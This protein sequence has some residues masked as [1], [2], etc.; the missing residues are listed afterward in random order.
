MW[1]LRKI[2]FPISLVYAF[3]VYL[4]NY[5]YNTKILS[6]NSFKTPTICIG[7]LSV[8][9]TGKTP[10]I[11]FL[12]SQFKDSYALVVLSRGYGRK[13]KGF[14]E[15]TPNSKVE[16]IG[17]E[18]F[19]IYSKFPEIKVV[20]DE[21]RSNAISRIEKEF[22]SDL[23]LLDD[24]YQHRKVTPSVSILLTTCQNL[25]SDDW[26]LPT[27][28]LRDSKREA[29][30]ADIIVVTKCPS[31][32]SVVEQKKIVGKLKSEF[33]QEVLFSYL[34]YGKSIVGEND[35]ISLEDY[36]NQEITLVT[37]IANPRP[38]QD[39]LTS[40]NVKFEHLKYKDHHFFT[41]KEL[42]IF[43]AKKMILTTEKDFVR[44]KNKVDNLYYISIKHKFIGN[45]KEEIEKI[46]TNV[47]KK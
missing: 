9:G 7:N 20:V 28:N 46:I 23:I 8:G 36:K 25:Y 6:S 27:G 35:N 38:L 29:K 32:I 19:Q 41:K 5:L 44:L 31:D 34:E 16:E 11:E 42:D 26:Y 37:G 12:V 45:G 33:H 43:N 18:P 14:L 2:S 3:V 13:T 15:A 4:R 17:D 40:K 24:A 39:Y 10:M 47:M 1:L 22:K 21:D 30:R